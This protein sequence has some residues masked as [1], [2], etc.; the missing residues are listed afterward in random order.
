[1]QNTGNVGY[2]EYGDDAISGGQNNS[3][4]SNANF[5]RFVADD[6]SV[7]DDNYLAAAFRSP[8]QKPRINTTQA[9][10]PRIP[11]DYYF[12]STTDF[13]IQVQQSGL[14]WNCNNPDHYSH[15]CPALFCKKC[16]SAFASHSD[17][18]YHK[19]VDCRFLPFKT[20]S[21]RMGKPLGPAKG[22]LPFNRPQTQPRGNQ[23][24]PPNRN[25][26]NRSPVYTPKAS[27]HFME[28]QGS[29]PSW[30][31]YCSMFER[32]PSAEEQGDEDNNQDRDC[33][34]MD[35]TMADIQDDT[36]AFVDSNDPILN[37]ALRTLLDSGANINAVPP[38][39]V[40]HYNLPVFKWKT[41]LTVTF[42]NKSTSSSDYYTCLGPVL[43]T[44]AIVTS[45]K[46]T[47]VSVPVVNSR[48]Y[49]LCVG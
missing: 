24:P 9:P 5:S 43:G 46:N 16:C 23:Q 35:A 2:S 38:I 12:P 30:D 31:H 21:A 39:A 32:A 47:I 7:F 22:P 33:G 41:P 26:Q 10:L 28:G 45:T 8:R 40:M 25:R 48:I 17:P 6:K 27:V 13:S 37:D 29:V 44:A 3:F 4:L 11:D 1:M 18:S 15:E 34:T 14:C 36:P 20:P 19:Y 49:L 42:G